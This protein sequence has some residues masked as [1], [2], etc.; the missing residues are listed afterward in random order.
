ME[1]SRAD[2]RGRPL[3]SFLKA[4]GRSPAWR[5]R[6]LR[7]GAAS[8]LHNGRR[9]MPRPRARLLLALLVTA[10]GGGGK[11]V[12]ERGPLRINEVMADDEG[13]TAIDEL[14]RLGDWVELVNTGE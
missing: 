1:S 13:G 8:R 9:T 4:E 2:A 12:K 14:G 11:V 7:P 5:A 6:E 3:L 10:C